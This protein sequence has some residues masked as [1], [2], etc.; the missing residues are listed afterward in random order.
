L[1]SMTVTERS[2]VAAAGWGRVASYTAQ[3]NDSHLR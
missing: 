3:G 2:F 1:K